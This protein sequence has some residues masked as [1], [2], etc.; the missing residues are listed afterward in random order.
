MVQTGAMPLD[1]AARRPRMYHPSGMT[2]SRRDVGY[3]RAAGARREDVRVWFGGSKIAALARMQRGRGGTR[4]S[5]P[6]M[7]RVL[8]PVVTN[9]TPAEPS[10]N[11]TI[12]ALAYHAHPRPAAWKG[13]PITLRARFIPPRSAS[14]STACSTGASI[15]PGATTTLNLIPATGWTPRVRR[16][17]SCHCR[18]E[19]ARRLGREHNRGRPDGLAAACGPA[20]VLETPSRSTQSRRQPVALDRLPCPEATLSLRACRQ[21]RARTPFSSEQLGATIAT[22]HTST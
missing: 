6:R 17:S 18:P 1:T 4:C 10:K 9:Y 12:V 19:P 11:G 13:V 5:L 8:Q 22:V 7:C 2:I 3:G 20:M 21:R 15:L 14:R 16:V